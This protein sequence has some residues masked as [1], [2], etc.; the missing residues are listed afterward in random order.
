VKDRKALL[1][2][3][4]VD[5]DLSNHF[6]TITAPIDADARPGFLDAGYSAQT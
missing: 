3:V 4:I 6:Q 5:P 1:A 2:Q